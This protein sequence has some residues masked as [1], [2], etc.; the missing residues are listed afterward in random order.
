MPVQNDRPG[1]F[2]LS[3]IILTSYAN[4]SETGRPNRLNIR[5]LVTEFN[6]YE[7]L[8]SK[9]LSGDMILTDATNVIQ[10][11]PLTGFERVEFFFRS[12]NTTV[13]Y[14]FGVDKGHPMFVYSLKNRKQINPNAQV[15]Q[16]K[17]ISLEGIRDHQTRVSQAFSG[18]IEQM[19]ADISN[20]FL[21]TKKMYW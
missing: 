9:F 20:N 17:F 6:I 14:D 5:N 19:I 21:K 18:N 16:L 12:P 4:D 13:G 7:S 10:T 8:D 15:Y 1:A 2:E 11:L 3:N